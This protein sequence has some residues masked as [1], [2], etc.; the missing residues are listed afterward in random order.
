MNE[1]MN[2]IERIKNKRFAPGKGV[3]QPIPVRGMR[4]FMFLLKTHFW[5]LVTLNLLL[6]IF[7]IPII[8]I[9]AAI[10]GANRVLV[11]LVINGNCLLW[12][13]FFQEFKANFFKAMPFGLFAVFT[14]FD[15]YYFLSLSISSQNDRIGIFTGALGVLFLVFTILFFS[16]VFVFLPVLD[17]KGRQIA[18]NAFIL[19]VTE[20]KANWIVL[21]GVAVTALFIIALF[22][23]TILFLLLISVVLMLFIISTAINEPLQ[24]RIIGPFQKHMDENI[25]NDDIC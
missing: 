21:S 3:D 22:P 24:R 1:S 14:L 5:K 23:Y 2:L 11:M 16:Y 18:R 6:I 19:M 17:L 10:C 9:P 13:E 7:S 15:S 8:T 20:W 4:R 12:P 25:Q